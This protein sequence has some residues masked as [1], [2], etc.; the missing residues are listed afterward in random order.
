MEWSLNKYEAF[1]Y[2]IQRQFPQLTGS[3]LIVKRHGKYWA[4]VEGTLFFEDNYALVVREVVDF[5]KNNFIKRYGYLVKKGAEILYWY[6]SQEHP[7]EP[8]LQLT[9]P[10]HKH[11][12]PNIK[13]NRIPATDL[14]FQQP[15]LPFIINEIIEKI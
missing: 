9:H 12:P 7:N 4:E 13:H 8:S 11:I 14:S 1:I 3:N 10:H 15:N 6:D 2:S 5:S